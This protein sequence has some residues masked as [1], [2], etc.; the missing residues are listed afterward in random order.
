MSQKIK[1]IDKTSSKPMSIRNQCLLLSINKSSL[2]LT[3]KGE[4][5]T[6]LSLME[7]I[8]KASY[9]D[10][11]QGVLRMTAHLQDKGYMVNPKRVRRLM[12]KMCIEAIYPKINLSKLGKA[13]YKQ[14]YLLGKMNITQPNQAWATDITYIPMKRGFMYLSALIDIYSRCIVGWNLSNSLDASIQ[15]QLVTD[16]IAKHGKPTLINS[17]QGSQYTS[18]IWIDCLQYHEVQISMDGKGRATDN[19]YIERFWRTIKQEY[20]YLHPQENILDL[21]KGIENY[22]HHYNNNRTHSAIKNKKPQ[23][24]FQKQNQILTNNS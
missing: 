6:N 12:R 13:I 18:K 17:D 1:M 8:D 11:T 7:Q 10:P 3:P 2:Y 22:I 5:A 9:Q 15:T 23:E 24:I 4:T 16:A 20:I 14:P 19:A 21:H